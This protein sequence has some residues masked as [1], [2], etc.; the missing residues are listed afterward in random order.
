MNVKSTGLARAGWAGREL[1]GE[2]EGRAGGREG[3]EAVLPGA[4]RVAAESRWPG[5]P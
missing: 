2:E 4:D 1:R 5:S 3:G